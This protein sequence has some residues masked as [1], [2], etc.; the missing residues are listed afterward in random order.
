M[1]KRAPG[2]PILL[3]VRGM[4][5]Y[6]LERFAEAETALRAA[7]A[8]APDDPA[9]QYWLGATLYRRG[10]AP[11]ARRAFGTV[12]RLAPNTRYSESARDFAASLR[13]GDAA[14]PAGAP[15]DRPWTLSV[16]TGLQ[17]DDNV[18]LVNAARVRSLRFFG[19]AEGSYTIALPG[20]FAL[21]FD[22]R[23]HGSAHTRG[24]ADDFNLVVLTGGPT[25]S[26][27]TNAAGLPLRLAAAYAFEHV[28]EGGR[29]YSTSHAVAARAE[30]TALPDSVTA[31]TVT[32]GFDRFALAAGS[33]PAIFSR[34]G[35]RYAAAIRH[36]HYL[37]GR[38]HYVWAG[39]EFTRYETEG[40]NFDADAHGGAAGVSVSL[41]WDV[42]LDFGAELI[43]T[44]YVHFVE[45]PQRRSFKQIYTAWLTKSIT[46]N[47][48]VS[49]AYA[50]SFDDSNIRDFETRRNVFTASARYAF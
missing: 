49:L 3:R 24:A 5:L 46:P 40:R 34:D 48:S 45:T 2:D 31:A 41:P 37:P 32:V 44:R 14:T 22:G 4:A 35:M 20:N 12:E 30:I 18:A 25:L 15:A 39:Y 33:A 7:V 1:L 36:I 29:F 27:R 8:A 28:M 43:H 16:T 23:V 42:R 47:L 9:A 21:T 6:R 19:E 26:W 13:D 17:H 38:R 10:D 11:G 50:Y